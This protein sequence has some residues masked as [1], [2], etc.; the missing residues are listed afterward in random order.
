MQHPMTCMS[1]SPSSALLQLSSLQYRYINVLIY[2]YYLKVSLNTNQYKSIIDLLR[3]N[4]VGRKTTENKEQIHT[5]LPLH[6]K[7]AC[8]H[9]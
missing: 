8:K 2:R 3:V 7:N 9:F 5:R 1:Q 6:K 4:T